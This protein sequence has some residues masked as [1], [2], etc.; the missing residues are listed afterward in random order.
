MGIFIQS[1]KSRP[2]RFDY[3]P[4]YYNP[5]RDNKVKKRMRIQSRV[6]R[7]RSPAGIIYF[8]LLL[9]MAVWIYLRLG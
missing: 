7:R 1:R 5:E 3:E 9:A 2:R 8:A 6:R 4:R